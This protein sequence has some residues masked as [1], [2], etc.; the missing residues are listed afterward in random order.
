MTTTFYIVD[1][2]Q[3][4]IK[5]LSNII[6]SQNLGSIVG[7]ANCGQDA[8]EDIKKQRLMFFYWIFYSLT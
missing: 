2:D 1:D 3:S 4:V 8:I 7:Y 5:I 6:K